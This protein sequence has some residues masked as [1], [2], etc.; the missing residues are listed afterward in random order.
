MAQKTVANLQDSVSGILTGLNLNNVKNLF[1]AFERTARNLTQKIS[2]PSARGRAS[3]ILYDGV[4]DY[5]AEEDIFGSNVIDLLPQ[6]NTRNINDYLYKSYSSDFDRTK[7]YLSNGTKVAFDSRKGVDILRIVSTKPIPKI[8]FDPMT[9]DTGWVAAG[10]ASGL[11]VDENVY[12]QESASLR[13][14]LTGASIGTLTKAIS[15]VDLTDYIGV[16]VVFLAIRTPSASDLTSIKIRIGSS[17]SAYYEVNATAG[18]LGSWTAGDWI[19]VALDLATATTTGSPTVTAID[20]AQVRITH[21]ATL[22]NFYVG[23]LWIALPSP[24]TLVYETAAVF[25]A[26]GANPSQSIVSVDDTILMSDGAYAIFEQEC[27][28]TVAKQQKGSVASGLIQSI[29]EELYGE[30][31]NVEKPGLYSLYRLDNP[32]EKVTQVGSWYDD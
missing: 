6:G 5:L 1:T 7:N 23:D 16:G 11:T 29:N 30:R 20:Y 8:E 15:S 13:F 26:S 24:H 18:I 28:K 27:S 9:D 25:M 17:A 22:T 31:G 12:Y 3:V 19:L 4:F 14:L 32:S 21:G 10:S 2:L